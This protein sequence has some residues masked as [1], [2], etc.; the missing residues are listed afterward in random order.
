MATLEL[1]RHLL[2]PK[3]HCRQ[4]YVGAPPAQN[5]RQNLQS[6]CSASGCAL[7]CVRPHR[8]LPAVTR[9]RQPTG[10]HSRSD[11]HTAALPAMA[12]PADRRATDQNHWSQTARQR[13]SGYRFSSERSCAGWINCSQPWCLRLG[14]SAGSLRKDWRLH[15]I[16]TLFGEVRVRV[17]LQLCDAGLI[18]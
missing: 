17:L 4:A 15:R 7:A 14:A 3:L 13:R 11:R 9:R 8:D 10:P 18:G 1:D 6:S 2:A 16:A 5:L 12:L